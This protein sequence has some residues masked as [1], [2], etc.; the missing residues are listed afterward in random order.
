MRIVQV[1]EHYEKWRLS[2]GFNQEMSTFLY[3]RID[4][5]NI[6]RL[7]VFLETHQID[8]CLDEIPFVMT[9]LDSVCKEIVNLVPISQDY[10][11]FAMN[12]TALAHNLNLALELSMYGYY[13]AAL[14]LMRSSIE[15]ML[16]L[17]FSS[18]KD[19][20]TFF[21]K[22]LTRISWPTKIG[23][24]VVHWEEALNTKDKPLPIFDMCVILDKLKMT[25]PLKGTY[26]FLEIKQLNGLVHKNIETIEQSDSFIGKQ[27][28][29]EFSANKR[30][31]VAKYLFKYSELWLI[32]IQN[33]RDCIDFE[34]K[35]IVLPSKE[36]RNLFPNYSNLI[37]D[38]LF[39]RI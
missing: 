24:R 23:K 17:C 1:P 7:N 27:A 36:L 37:N 9:I 35:P 21:E 22:L 26:E 10:C 3:E 6:N 13:D 18:I 33:A 34:L 31:E 19:K 4:S 28:E 15:G 25:H 14:I 11:E 2:Q 12:T 32:L 30:D 5:Q 20:Q 29:R 16:R 8:N 39:F 38:R